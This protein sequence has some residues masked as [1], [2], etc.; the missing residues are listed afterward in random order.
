M[1]AAIP[2]PSAPGPSPMWGFGARGNLLAYVRDPLMTS[3]R[4]FARYGNVASVVRAPISI[5]NPGPG[6]GTGALA[7]ANGAGVVI[8][9]GAD[10]NREV[11]T[12]HE[13]YHTIALPG[14]LYP[15]TNVSEREKPV[16]RMFTGL[17]HV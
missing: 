11:L 1:P 16:T 17:F 3:G 13:R 7:T 6:W 4:I 15:T 5:V 14:R 9:T 2:I 8:A 12:Q 10:V